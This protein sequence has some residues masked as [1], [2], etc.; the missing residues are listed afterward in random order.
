MTLGLISPYAV[1][2]FIKLNLSGLLFPYVSG[3]NN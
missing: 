1:S 2:V 3:G